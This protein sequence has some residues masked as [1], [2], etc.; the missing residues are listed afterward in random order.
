MFIHPI[1]SHH[2]SLH[3]LLVLSA[4]LCLYLQLTRSKGR[5]EFTEAEAT[6]AY[7]RCFK[8]LTSSASAHAPSAASSSANSAPGF[9]SRSSNLTFALNSLYD[10]V[11]FVN[12]FLLS[13]TQAILHQQLLHHQ[14]LSLKTVVT[15]RTL[16]KASQT[17]SKK[18][19]VVPL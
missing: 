2:H 14:V 12:L 11:V 3:I 13:I 18:S 6:A 17:D 8:Q 19:D 1:P 5:L 10:T 4:L 15:L 16:Q 9:R 7:D